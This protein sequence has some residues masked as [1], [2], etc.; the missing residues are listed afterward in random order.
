MRCVGLLVC[1]FVLKLA[2]GKF[3]PST[4]DTTYLTHNKG[5]KLCGIFSETAPLQSQ[6]PSNIVRLLR[7][8]AI[9]SACTFCDHVFHTCG[10]EGSAL[11]CIHLAC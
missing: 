2:C 9:L 1:L 7:K 11:L 3:I 4:N 5:V 10:A 8:S 6:S